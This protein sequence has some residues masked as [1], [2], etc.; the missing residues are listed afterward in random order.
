MAPQYSRHNRN[1]DNYDN[2]TGEGPTLVA[3]DDK[4]QRSETENER[5]VEDATN[6]VGAGPGLG[7]APQS[8]KS[9]PHDSPH[10]QYFTNSSKRHGFRRK[11]QPDGHYIPDGHEMSKIDTAKDSHPAGRH[12]HKL[13]SIAHRLSPRLS[14]ST[15]ISQELLE[16]HLST[17][18]SIREHLGLPSQAPL[19]EGHEQQSFLT[20]PTI[21]IVFREPFAEFFGTFIMIIF[22]CGSVAQVLLSNAAKGSIDPATAPGGAGWGDYQSISWGWGIGVMLGIY[23][24]GDSGGFLNPAITLCFCLFRKL[25]WRRLPIYMAAQIL[26][27]FLAAGV[28]YGVYQPAINQVEGGMG[29]TVPP[30]ETATA[31][32]FSTYPQSFLSTGNMF[33]SEV[34]SSAILMF[35]IFAMKDDSNPGA[36]GK[37]GA[38]KLFPLVL[39]FLIFGLGACFGWET[40]YAINLARDFGPRLMSYCLGYGPGVWSAG[41]YYFWIPMVAPFVGTLI[42]AALYDVFVY[43]GPESP[44]NRQWFGF[45][46]AFELLQQWR[47]RGLKK[48]G[49]FAGEESKETV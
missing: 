21:R 13:S 48:D 38:G 4:I 28:I 23:V 15:N 39:F 5:H 7:N 32:V 45:A 14:G 26:G 9:P 27:A 44:V 11:S 3:E 1:E 42:G 6:K 46:A 37:S 19:V 20:W 34:V 16:E 30:A 8:P 35:V 49:V 2:S 29:R 40:G 22:G 43:T 31:G 25:P 36:M 18:A 47:R 33:T 17:L 12:A 10:S 24:A 41:N